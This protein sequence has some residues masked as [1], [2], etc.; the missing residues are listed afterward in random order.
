MKR[1]R[2]RLTREELRELAETLLDRQM[3]QQA[4]HRLRAHQRLAL[5]RLQQ[6]QPHVYVMRR[7]VLL[8]LRKPPQIKPELRQ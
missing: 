5:E 4:T 6:K 2:K 7:G 3:E 1:N 8:Q